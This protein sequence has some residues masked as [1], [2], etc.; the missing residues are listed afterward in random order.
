MKCKTSLIELS[1]AELSIYKSSTT[2]SGD[3]K[4]VKFYNNVCA[5][6]DGIPFRAY[7]SSA[8]GILKVGVISLLII[9]FGT[10]YLFI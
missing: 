7:N 9:I 5:V 2:C 8:N 6:Y 4:P 3:T 10:I 1:A